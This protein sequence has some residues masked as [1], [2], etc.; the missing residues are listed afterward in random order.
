MLLTRR[1]WAR[2][3][4][5]GF[6]LSRA[7]GQSNNAPE[8][9]AGIPVNYDESRVGQYTLPDPLRLANGQPVKTA[10]DWTGKRRPEIIRLYEENQFGRSPAQPD[11]LSFDVFD[12]GT[13]A[14]KGAVTRKQVTVHFSR[15]KSGPKA[16]VLMYLPA[17]AKK[18][19][20]VLL[21]PSFIANSTMVSDPGVK[22][23]EI[24]DRDKKRVPAPKESRF[25]KFDV[26]RICGQALALQRSITATSI[27]I[28]KEACRTEFERL[29]SNPG[30]RNSGRTSGVQSRLGLGD[31]AGSLITL[32]RRKMSMRSVS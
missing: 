11:G 5:S 23:G 2:A 32:R 3:A 13:P 19:V 12:K 16:D 21:T 24:W 17:L 1:Q 18:P 15:E 9:V 7:F 6:Y 22:Q 29:N 30:K 28:L 20:P 8:N 31:S 25:A 4:G 26:E 10:K 14:Y 27:R